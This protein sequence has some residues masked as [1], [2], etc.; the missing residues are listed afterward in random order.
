MPEGVGYSGS[1]VVAGTGLELNY[2]G[3]H[4]FAY[5]GVI[6]VGAVQSQ[7]YN[8][9]DFT[10][11]NRTIRALF[12]PVNFEPANVVYDFQWKVYLNS[13]LVYAFIVEA[14]NI[15]TPYEEIDLIVPPLTGVL[16][17]AQNPQAGAGYDLGAVFTGKLV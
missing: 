9:L 15:A 6:D 16:I 8:L 5:S 7:E 17:T 13:I 14:G 4:V 1:N 12:Q 10:T 11:G 3:D 2:V